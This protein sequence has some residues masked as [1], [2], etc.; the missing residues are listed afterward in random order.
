MPPDDGARYTLLVGEGVQ[1]KR[2]VGERDPPEVGNKPGWRSGTGK[3]NERRSDLRRLV[4]HEGAV[5]S[6]FRAR[7]LRPVA[8]AF[9]AP[10]QPG[11]K[12]L[13]LLL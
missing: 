6:E 1:V 3:R 12:R 11:N 8:V 2:R 13:V 10:R 5:H 4:L 7:H 9:V